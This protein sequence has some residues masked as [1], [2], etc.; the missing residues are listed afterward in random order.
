MGAVPLNLG[1]AAPASVA[2]ISD[3]FPFRYHPPPLFPHFRLILRLSFLH[4]KLLLCILPLF[5][6]CFSSP[7][8]HL[9]LHLHMCII[10]RSQLFAFFCLIFH[11]FLYPSFAVAPPP[12]PSPAFHLRRP[13]IS[14]PLSIFRLFSH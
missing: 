9:S 13:I 8:T 6:S 1:N 14:L 12:L 3:T 4:S 10:H 2:S 5:L 7:S 11:R